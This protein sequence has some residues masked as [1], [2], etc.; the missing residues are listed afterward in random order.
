V[1][2]QSGRGAAKTSKAEMRAGSC[3]ALTG[4]ADVKVQTAAASRDRAVED[5]VT[6]AATEL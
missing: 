5:A 4:D 3:P 1:S 6:N 2:V